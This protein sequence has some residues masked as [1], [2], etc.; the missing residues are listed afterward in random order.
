MRMLPQYQTV[1]VG[2]VANATLHCNRIEFKK[3][4]KKIKEV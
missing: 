3:N 1:S 2:T 4:Y